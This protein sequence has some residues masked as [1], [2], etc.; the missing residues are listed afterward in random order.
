MRVDFQ[1][2]VALIT[3]CP[4]LKA[5]IH[6]LAVNPRLYR[7]GVERGHRTYRAQIAVEIARFTAAAET[8]TPG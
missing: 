6:D 7:H 8:G 4:S 3:V 5:N 2:Q 1:Q